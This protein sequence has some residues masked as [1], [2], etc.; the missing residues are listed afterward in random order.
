ML[1]YCFFTK[2]K[3]KKKKKTTTTTKVHFDNCV[4]TK[5]VSMDKTKERNK[6]SFIS[7]ELEPLRML[8]AIFRKKISIS[9]TFYSRRK[10]TK[11]RSKTNNSNS[12]R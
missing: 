1:L 7:D 5:K 10:H 3:K 4:V 9:Y 8:L 12:D 2:K 6:T 11:G